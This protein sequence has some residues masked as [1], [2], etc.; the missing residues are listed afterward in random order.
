MLYWIQ[1]NWL[2]FT[3]VYVLGSEDFLHIS[4]Q[5]QYVWWGNEFEAQKFS[6]FYSV[7]ITQ[8]DFLHVLA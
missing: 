7:K 6:V 1:L 4:N 8:D 2:I 5:R 3:N